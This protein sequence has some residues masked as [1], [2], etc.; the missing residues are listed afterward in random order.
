MRDIDINSNTPT[1]ESEGRV[2]GI[3]DETSIGEVNTDVGL[4]WC[5]SFRINVFEKSMSPYFVLPPDME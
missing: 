4:I 2:A 5:V 1:D 3:V